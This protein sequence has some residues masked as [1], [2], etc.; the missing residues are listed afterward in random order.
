MSL[1]QSND[2]KRP[3]NNSLQ[4]LPQREGFLSDNGVWMCDCQP[5]A[6]ARKLQTTKEG[7]N[8]RRWCMQLSLI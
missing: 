4:K 3:R 7:Q 8:F 5:R 2:Q 1:S 6:Q